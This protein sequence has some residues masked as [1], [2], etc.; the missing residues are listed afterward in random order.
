MESASAN[1]L[2]LREREAAKEKI[3]SKENIAGKHL[4]ESTEFKD[5]EYAD[6]ELDLSTNNQV[7]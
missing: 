5:I 2:G 3:H 4:S 6:R 7:L 1:V